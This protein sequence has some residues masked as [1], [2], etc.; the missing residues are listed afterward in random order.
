MIHVERGGSGPLLVLLHGLGATGE[1]WRGVVD[2]W[3]GA[4]LVPDLPGHGRSAPLERYSFGSFAAAVASVVPAGPVAV[5]GH[6]LG[7]VVALTLASGWFGVDVSAV[8]GVGIKLRW[9][10]GELERAAGL[11]SRPRR[12]SRRA[13]RRST[14]RRSSPACPWNTVWFRTAPGGVPCS[15][16]PP[17]AWAHRMS[18]GCSRRRRRRSPW[19]PA[20]TTT[21]APRWISTPPRR[22]EWCWQEWVT[23][24]TWSSRRRSTRSWRG[25]AGSSTRPVIRSA[26]EER[27]MRG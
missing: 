24:P 16:W 6:S 21:C 18:K 11:A 19:P 7:G 4:W 5:L 25:W 3:P 9:T 17:S 23:T 22:V 15:T 13:P 12:S 26:V 20:S 2:R 1:V 27:P 10:P 14:G 8:G